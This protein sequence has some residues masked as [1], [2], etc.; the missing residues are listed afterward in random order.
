MKTNREIFRDNLLSTVEEI[1][2]KKNINPDKSYKFMITTIK[3]DGKPLSSKDDVMRLIVLSEKNIKN[4]FFN[5][6]EVIDLLSCLDPV[7]PLWVRVLI[8]EEQNHTI[9]LE[10]QTSLRFRKPKE[11]RNK[12]TGHPPF[13]AGE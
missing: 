5:L 11:L 10:L 2:A 7:Y 13:I 3:E 1:F 8:K 6:E 12:E 4:R 9:L